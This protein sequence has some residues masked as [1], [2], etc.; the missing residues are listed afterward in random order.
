MVIAA[1]AVHRWDGSLDSVGCLTA[2]IGGA[3]TNRVDSFVF[4]LHYLSLWHQA[5]PSQPIA[6]VPDSEMC[7]I[8]R[9]FK[10]DNR[11]NNDNLIS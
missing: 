2:K 1:G 5:E 7:N 6:P 4:G 8:E 3:S 11:Y 10:E 9:F